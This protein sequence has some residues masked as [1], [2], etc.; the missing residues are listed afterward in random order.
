MLQAGMRAIDEGEA[1]LSGS[2]EQNFKRWD[3]LTKQIGLGAVDPSKYGTYEGQIGYLRDFL[4][5]RFAYMDQRIR[6]EF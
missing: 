4:T 1:R 5:K 6:T 3:I 2:Q